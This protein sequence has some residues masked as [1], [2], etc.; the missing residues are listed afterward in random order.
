MLEV[1]HRERDERGGEHEVRGQRP[2][3][4]E[5]GGDG[6]EQRAAHDRDDATRRRAA[7]AAA[8]RRRAGRAPAR[9]QRHARDHRI[10]QPADDEPEHRAADDERRRSRR[11]IR[12]R[13]RRASRRAGASTP[14]HSSN[15]SAAWCTSMPSPLAAGHA[16]GAGGGEQR[17]LHRVVHG[18]DHELAGVETLHGSTGPGPRPACRAAWRSRRASNAPGVARPPSAAPVTAGTRPAAG[19]GGLAAAGRDRDPARR[20]RRARARSPGPRRRHRARARRCP[21][22]VDALVAHRAE[23]ALAVGRRAEEPPVVATARPCSPRR[24]RSPSGVSSSH[25]A[26]GVRLVRHRDAE[27]AE[28]ERCAP[29][30]TASPPRPARHRERDEHPVEPGGRERGVVDRRRARVRG[31]GRR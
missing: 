1:D 2:R 3:V 16:A 10:E 23:E 14:V 22:R 17:R 7:T 21:R 30:S 27:P 6:A 25:A 20:R 11:R 12:R 13:R 19:V 8:R 29:P 9:L 24:A 31:P 18:V 5:A 4:V 28:P 26:R 15:A